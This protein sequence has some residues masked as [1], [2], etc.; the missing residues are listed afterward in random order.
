MFSRFE[1]L[2]HP[3]PETAPVPPPSGFVPFVWAC[4]HGLRRYIAA[5]A[6]LVAVIGVFEAFLFSMLGQVVDWLGRVRPDRLWAD[7]GGTLLL[8]G[9]SSSVAS[10]W[11]ACGAC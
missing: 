11:S 2:V 10:P 7:E 8:L 3:Y 5:I 4:T 9:A 1:R 6:L